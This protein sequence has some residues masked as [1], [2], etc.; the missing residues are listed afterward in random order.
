MSCSP[1]DL[2]DYILGELAET[3]H[4]Q[5]DLHVR[6]CGGCQEDLEQLRVTHATLL[7]LREEE[8]PQRIGFVSD[9]VFEP[10]WPRRVWQAFWASSPK[11]GFASAAMLSAALI[12]VTFFRPAAAVPASAASLDTARIEAQVSERVAAT[13]GKAV[14]ESEARQARKTTELL[15]AAEQRFRQQRISDMERVGEEFS[16]LQ[17]RY[18]VVLHASYLTGGGQ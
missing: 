14:A 3:Q 17:K 12:A 10:S 9:K 5:V 8:V 4:R 6:S 7:S 2:R 13:V 1:F 16:Y 11:L 18:N 15:A